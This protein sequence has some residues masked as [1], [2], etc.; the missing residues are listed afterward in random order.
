MRTF[1]K[2]NYDWTM[3]WI[4]FSEICEEVYGVPYDLQMGERGQG[5][6]DVVTTGDEAEIQG[7]WTGLGQGYGYDDKYIEGSAYTRF[8]EGD[9]EE[10][11]AAGEKAAIEHWQNQKKIQISSGAA[12][13]DRPFDKVGENGEYTFY[14]PDLQVV[15]N[16]LVNREEIPPGTYM[17]RIEW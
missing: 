6:Y 4:E 9:S 12:E 10:D 16:D 13:F 11:F 3:S 5:E 2:P 7:R 14:Q 15:M 17:I 8:V 1:E